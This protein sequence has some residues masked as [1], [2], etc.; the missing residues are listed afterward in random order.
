M[1]KHIKKT[2]KMK[3]P[4]EL[5]IEKVEK[6]VEEPNTNIEITEKIEFEKYGNL[7][8]NIYSQI[9]NMKTSLSLLANETKKMQKAIQKET[10]NAERKKQR[11]GSKKG[12]RE[13]S[14]FAKPAVISNELCDF[15]SVP[16]GTEMARTEV[17]K[18]LTSY[19]KDNNL[20]QQEDKR[21]IAPD[22]KLQKLL[23]ITKEDQVTYFN[24]QKWMKPHFPSSTTNA[25]IS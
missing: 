6:A 8:D 4:K 9:Y 1:S 14:G 21:K 20:Q 7:F 11:V 5:I 15:L 17:T 19:I 10:K 22:K 24:L 12:K 16:F 25:T 13:P 23:K 18:F 3:E 2:P